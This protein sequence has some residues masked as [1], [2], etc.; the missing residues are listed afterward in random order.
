[1]VGILQLIKRASR[2]QGGIPPVRINRLRVMSERQK[3]NGRELV[4]VIEIV[5]VLEEDAEKYPYACR[6][7]VRSSC[8]W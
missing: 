1:M 5:E 6:N 3:K 7:A 2:G 8:H 4:D